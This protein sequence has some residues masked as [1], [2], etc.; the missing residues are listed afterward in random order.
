MA[1]AL[2]EME[3]IIY[4]VAEDALKEARVKPAEVSHICICEK[5]FHC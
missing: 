2:E 4:K 3:M 1:S 5:A